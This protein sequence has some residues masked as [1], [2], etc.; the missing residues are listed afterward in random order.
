[1][2]CETWTQ[3]QWLANSKPVSSNTPYTLTDTRY[4]KQGVAAHTIATTTGDFWGVLPGLGNYAF[5]DTDEA[6]HYNT[7]AQAAALAY[8]A[9]NGYEM[10]DSVAPQLVE[11]VS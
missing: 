7:T 3:E 6:A 1:M 9:R 2:S 11:Y 5:F 4:N 10:S 8:L